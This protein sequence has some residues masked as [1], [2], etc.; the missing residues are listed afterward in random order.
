MRWRKWLLLVAALACAG[1]TLSAS[2]ANA[3]QYCTRVSTCSSGG[4]TLLCLAGIFMGYP[5]CLQIAPCVDFYGGGGEEDM[6]FKRPRW[7]V[8]HGATPAR[9]ARATPAVGTSSLEVGTQVEMYALFFPIRSGFEPF[10][11]G[12]TSW[13]ERGV[14][15]PRTT[16]AFLSAV[17]RHSGLLP[18]R[19][20]VCE[21]RITVGPGT[22]R[23]GLA[24]LG[25]DGYVIDARAGASGVRVRLCAVRGRSVIG[26]L[27]DATI[28]PEDVLCVRVH[29]NG[30]D[31]AM[32]ISARALS[33]E[34]SEQV[35]AASA[36]RD[37]FQQVA[38]PLTGRATPF[39]SPLVPFEPA[40]SDCR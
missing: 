39:G 17:A 2:T 26:P 22:I 13:V 19:L 21:A 16:G 31:Q 35:Q 33:E 18:E 8:V 28:A 24:D 12:A 37:R 30:L 4:F 36:E 11:S 40:A 6:P 29:A 32:A 34:Q 14:S 3:C 9:D 38:G 1:A 5:Y 20:E 27:A 10:E 25:G 7:P 15:E 23:V